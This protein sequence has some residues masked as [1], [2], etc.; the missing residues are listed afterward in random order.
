MFFN[1]LIKQKLVSFLIKTKLLTKI[2][3]RK[4]E[5]FKNFKQE[6]TSTLK[7]LD[8]S[9]SSIIFDE[10]GLITVEL[11]GED[12]VAAVNYLTHL[13]GKAQDL[14]EIKVGDI[15]KGYVCSSGKVGFGVFV[16]I[17]IKEPYMTDALLPLF[18]LRK[19]LFQGQKLPVKKIITL[20]SL[21]DNFPLEIQINEVSIGLKKIEAQFSENQLELFERWIEEGLDRLIIIGALEKEITRALERS[22]HSDDIIAIE[23]LGWLEFSLTCKFNT[24]AKGLIPEIGRLLPKATFEILSPGAIKK[25][26][27]SD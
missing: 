7:E 22:K 14:G 19:Q 16:D 5:N 23:K 3:T 1:S 11:T 27:K 2:H 10:N 24:S 21:I 13:Y 26:L 15:V 12:E 18:N 6:L 4:Q 20:Y 9:I 25:A 8:V 17:G